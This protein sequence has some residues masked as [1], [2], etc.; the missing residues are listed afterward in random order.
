MAT[1]DKKPVVMGEGIINDLT[2]GGTAAAL[3][4]E[5]GKV[6]G[7]RPN[8][9]LL[10]NW[11]FGNPVNQRGQ[12]EYTASNFSGVYAIDRWKVQYAGAKIVLGSQGIEVYGGSSAGEFQLNQPLD[13]SRLLPN[14]TYTVFVDSD[15]T[16]LT[17]LLFWNGTQQ[18]RETKN[19]ITFTTP[20]T[21]CTSAIL[22]VFCKGTP[23]GKIG[24]IKAIKLELGSTQTL[25]HQDA[26][27]NWVL[28]EIPDYGEELRKCRRYY[29]Q[30]F[31]GANPA[32]QV[33]WCVF[34][35]GNANGGVAVHWEEPMR[36]TPSVTVY[37]SAGVAN[38]VK[39][40]AGTENPTEIFTQYVSAHGFA[41]G[42]S[43]KFTVG[44]AYHFHYAASA[45]L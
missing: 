1:G 42:G 29:R 20:N 13:T 4:A 26:D 9:N 10:D 23:S 25:A 17:M 34:V 7:Q 39:N 24:T 30:S 18:W 27:G 14:T 37:D 45:D 33:G 32:G 15:I 38:A 16:D 40:W 44:T 19:P 28:N 36:A 31:E 2:T 5:M 43:G 35:A 21:E 12:T 22:F 3:S 6:L 41:I 11:Y 8:P